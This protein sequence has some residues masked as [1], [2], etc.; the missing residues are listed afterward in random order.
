MS[1]RNGD[2]LSCGC[3]HRETARKNGI[4]AAIDLTG[5]T[6]GR[7]TVTRRAK[8][9]PGMRPKW[10]CECACGSETIIGG[11]ALASGNTVS[12]GCARDRGDRLRPAEL[13]EKSRIYGLR[14]RARYRDAYRPY[15]EFALYELERGLHREA[16]KRD[17]ETGERWDIDHIVPII[18]PYSKEL[19]GRIVCG[20]H[21]EHN[22][23][24]MRRVD[25]GAKNNRWWPGMP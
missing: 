14:R 9:A 25:N 11:G 2:T 15:D 22:L 10:L 16:T 4:A 3:L 19:G 20:L 21:N 8:V 6:F 24:I 18:G 1:L 13:V 7:L 23:Q 5:R 17:R 12:C